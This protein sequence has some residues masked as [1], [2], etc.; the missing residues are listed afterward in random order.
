MT[1]A[2][3]HAGDFVERKRSIE[4]VGGGSAAEAVGGIGGL[5]LA[6]LG[7]AGVLPMLLAEIATI[8]IGAS[9][10]VE[11]GVVGARI[12]KLLSEIGGGVMTVAEVGGGMSVE[13]LAGLAGVVLGILALL[14]TFPET[15]MAASVVV[16]GGALLLAS[17]VTS[18]LNALVLEKAGIQEDAQRIAAE[19]V[20]VASGV[21]ILLGLGALTL[22][23]VALVGL[24]PLTL[25][26]VGLLVSGAAVTISGTALASRMM[27][28]VM[29]H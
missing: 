4:F 25:V 15:L 20:T 5:V 2:S 7:L 10:L 12:R 17:G 23:V 28:A 8:A 9:L 22:G 27:A 13:I 1:T 14:G 29:G 3:E 21:Q 26:L 18:R 16:F 24:V 6:I 11:G 19:A